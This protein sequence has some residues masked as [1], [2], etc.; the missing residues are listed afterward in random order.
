[1]GSNTERQGRISVGNTK[2]PDNIFIVEIKEFHPWDKSEER[3]GDQKLTGKIKI[4]P[5][6]KN[7]E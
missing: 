7:H 2:A 4:W 6:E 1:M 3:F 5:K